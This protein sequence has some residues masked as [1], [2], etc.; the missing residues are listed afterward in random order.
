M[1]SGWGLFRGRDP[2][3]ARELWL[4]PLL[5]SGF[6]GDTEYSDTVMWW[7]SFEAESLERGL[8][9]AF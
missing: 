2:R 1:G 5:K 3:V 9:K 6:S 4:C 7:T 8:Q